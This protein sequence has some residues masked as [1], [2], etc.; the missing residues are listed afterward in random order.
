MVTAPLW[1]TSLVQRL[2]IVAKDCLYIKV[3]VKE[4]GEIPVREIGAR[5]T[6]ALATANVAASKVLARLKSLA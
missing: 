1:D 3:T 5:M 6:A 2:D 4:A